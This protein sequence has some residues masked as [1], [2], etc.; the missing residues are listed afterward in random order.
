M[1]HIAD[2]NG[3]F[4]IDYPDGVLDCIWPEAPSADSG[5]IGEKLDWVDVSFDR[6]LYLS[7]GRR[8]EVEGTIVF[9]DS[10]QGDSYLH[11]GK[12]EAGNIGLLQDWRREGP[13]AFSALGTEGAY[14]FHVWAGCQ[15]SEFLRGYVCN[16]ADYFSSATIDTRD[17][18]GA[19]VVIPPPIPGEP[20]IPFDPPR[21]SLITVGA[22]DE[23]GI[24]RVSGAPGAATGVSWIRIVNLNTGHFVDGASRGDGSFDIDF[25]APPGSWLE[26]RQDP[27]AHSQG[28]EEGAGTIIRVPYGDPSGTFATMGWACEWCGTPAQESNP[29]RNVGAHDYGQTWISGDLQKQQWQAG[30]SIPLS[31]EVKVFTRNARQIAP[32]SLDMYGRVVLE[33]VFDPSGR[34][35]F[36]NPVFVSQNLTPTGLPIERKGQNGFRGSSAGLFVA[37]DIS[38]GEWTE[39][40]GRGFSSS[41]SATAVV[42]PDM[43]DGVYSVVIEVF[44]AQNRTVVDALHFEDTFRQLFDT[45]FTRS[46]ATTIKIGSPEPAR[47]SWA[48]GLNTLSNGARGTVAIED[49]DRIGIANRVTTNSKPFIVPMADARN[50]V[51]F[52]YRLEPFAPL[53]GTSNR[54]WM[55]PPP[56]EFD[57]PSGELT[58]SIEHPDGSFTNI[59][60]EPFAQSF[61]QSPHGLSGNQLS[62]V[63]NDPHQYFGLTTL[64]PKFDVT[65]D[66]YGLHRITMTGHLNDV[67]GNR[68]E[69]GGTYEVFVA[70]HLDLETGVF[71][72]TPFEVGDTISPTVIV[73]PGVP[74]DVEIKV[75]HYPES[76]P[77]QRVEYVVAGTA[78]RFGYFHPT[79][80]DSF[81][82]AQPGEYRFDIVASYEDE[83]GVLWMGAES[84]ASVVETPGDTLVAHGLRV[85]KRDGRRDQW[86]I[87][88]S[89]SIGGGHLPFPYHTGDIAW[90]LE[91]NF[92][93]DFVAMFPGLSVQDTQGDFID[94]LKLRQQARFD[95]HHQEWDE[96]AATG[97]I[98]LFSSTP[99]YLPAVFKP[100]APDTHWGYF[101]SGAARPGVRI[102][103]MVSEDENQESYWRFDDTYNYQPGNGSNG[104]LPNDFKFQFGGTV[105]RAPDRGFF[106]YGAYGSLWVMVPNDDPMG[107]RVMP[108]FQGNGGGPSGGPIMTLKGRDIDLFFHP[109]GIRPG[110]I[111]ESG[112]IV[113]IAGQF[114]PTLSSQLEVEITEPGGE[115][116]VVNGQANKVGYFYDPEQDF[117]VE[118]PGVY[119]V[120]VT[121][122][123]TGRTSAGQVQQPY[124][125][126]DVLGSRSGEFYFYVVEPDSE[127]LGT[128]VTESSFVEPGKQAIPI[129][130]TQTEGI[131]NAK[132][133]FTTVMPG[134]IL[135]EGASNGLEYVYDAQELAET[136][137]NLD[138]EDEDARYGVDTITMSFLVTGEDDAG[139]PVYRARQILLQGEELMAPRQPA[140]EAEPFAINAGH[141]GAWF[142]PDTSGQGQLIDI[143]PESQFMFL[144]WFTFTDDDSDNPNQQ[145]WLTAQ[146]NY[147]GNKAVLPVYETLGGQFD[148]PAEVDPPALIG[149]IELSFED[150][151]SGQASY[152]IDSWEVTGS[153]PLSR[154]VPGSENVCLV[155]SGKPEET[156]AQNDAWDGAWYK[157][158][159]SGQGFLID[160]KSN[161]EGDDFIFVAWFTYGDTNA[162]GQRWLTA[163]GP[164][165][166]N[167]AEIPIY[168][169]TGGSFDDPKPINPPEN[170]GSMN[171]EFT[172]CNSAQLSY[173]LTAEGLQGSMDI[174][175]VIPGTE[176]LCESLGVSD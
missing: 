175:R 83:D 91:T 62:G 18:E 89:S 136:F 110:S 75:S 77:G 76:D 6:E 128:E 17:E 127:P 118:T 36:T 173:D 43:P 14:F 130:L 106:H 121:A 120:K 4:S 22:P 176:A 49:R 66:Q 33:R 100:D 103:D 117:A 10:Y 113:S 1:E 69:G 122:R 101:Y 135:E 25:L 139:N 85:R 56:I 138:L 154:V 27:T 146:G 166:G 15:E 144:A 20:M 60:S 47:L 82:F 51:P 140:A 99:N 165:T 58:V 67:H 53:L 79:S 147:S 11:A 167:Q 116:T 112:D 87:N 74:A 162:S 41:W 64:N 35:E 42:P 164:M 96:L 80:G 131:R 159:T 45:P 19:T 90:S 160:S 125:T 39:M 72:N 137:P 73:Q 124:P 48:L 105:Y 108:P 54:G 12:I 150:C 98:L 31:G 157:A 149:S 32:D 158:D 93:P 133:Y 143:E 88:D 163:Q 134:F 148:D 70:R 97:E 151:T 161:A 46:H 172:G 169:I 171:I 65:F 92:D 8:V 40:D 5:L 78:N 104:D 132:L 61:V 9:P 24:A 57:F 13:E 109:T 71:A 174:E 141:S 23:G 126:G 44:E 37:E 152:S 34:Q 84:W 111:L 102:R 95:W 29:V 30:E 114:G 115:I 170:I 81:S 123:Y 107:I 2:E 155:S 63:S 129:E 142:N 52:S 153:F 7:L 16:F 156:I 55:P 59:G 26:V 119:K 28:S 168:E 3:N 68:Y 38:F 94:L 50:D 145:H 86:I 21:A